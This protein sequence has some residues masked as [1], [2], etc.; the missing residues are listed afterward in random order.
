[1][2]PVKSNVSIT[3]NGQI[4]LAQ[5]DIAIIPNIAYSIPDF[6]GQ[7]ILRIFANSTQ[8]EIAC[9]SAVVTNGATFSHPAA[10]GTIL[11]IFAFVAVIA[12]FVTAIY[13]TDIPTMRTHYAHSLSVLVVFAVFQHIFFTGA[14]SMNWPSVLVAFWSNYAW[15]AGI[16]Y[17][18]S[19]QDAF[20]KLTHNNRGNTSM[21]GAAGTDTW[22]SNVGGGYDIHQIYKRA[23]AFNP[24][25]LSK[26]FEQ[27]LSKRASSGT[28]NI[29]TTKYM[30]HLVRAG[31]PLPGNYSGFPG[32]LYEEEI[33]ASNA[34]LT[35]LVWF[36]V[37]ILI[38]G[39]G[40]LFFKFAIEGLS[41]MKVIKTE[42]LNYFRAHYLGY[43]TAAVL[44]TCFIGFFAM[45][46]YTLFQF[47]YGGSAAVL[48]IAGIVFAIFFIGI[49]GVVGYA[50]YY[51]LRFD[52]WAS[53]RGRYESSTLLGFI[54]WF[55]HQQ[56]RLLDV[57]TDE[58][59][60]PAAEKKLAVDRKVTDSSENFSAV[61][62]STLHM[63]ESQKSVH[64]DEQFIK[65]FGWLASRYRK[66]K[67]WF[68][69]AWIVYEFVR[70]C[71]FAG[72]S[73]H[74]MVQVFGLLIV[75]FIAFMAI[76][77][78]RPFEG[79][80]LNLI[81]VYLLG[82]SKVAT[83]AL[84]AA[85]D[86]SFNLQR[87]T[88]TAIG[89][90]IIVIQGVVT[91]V[92]MICIV[93]SA[94]TSYFSV[95]RYREEIKPKK[96]NKH[97]EKYFK[98]LNQAVRDRPV[99]PPLV[100]PTPP[101]EE[102]K[103]PY[104]SV[105]SVRRAPKIEDEDPEFLADIAMDPRTSMDPEM[106]RTS[107]NNIDNIYDNREA[108]GTGVSRPLSTSSRRPVTHLPYAARVHRGS[109]S[110]RDFSEFN[111]GLGAAA[112]TATPLSDNEGMRPASRQY[113]TLKSYNSRD[114]IQRSATT[115]RSRSA[116]AIVAEEIGI[117]DT[118]S[119]VYHNSATSTP[120]ISRSASLRDAITA[121]AAVEASSPNGEKEKPLSPINTA[122]VR[123]VDNSNISPPPSPRDPSH[124]RSR[125]QKHK[126]EKSIAEG[127]EEWP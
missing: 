30:G 86:I 32:T 20:D 1:M 123:G 112:V 14:L 7:A 61:A 110:T 35:A 22:A 56:P 75:E 69:A 66:S 116:S 41:K 58:N 100:E 39:S 118:V 13:G 121:A 3:A 88:T 44:R 65:R 4:P 114:S 5:S 89:I 54:P 29:T 37:L 25:T 79:Q 124:T 93:L 80:R 71:F 97:Q 2:C 42:R 36:L 76:I 107:F 59:S 127:H 70:A 119:P 85:F 78:I 60:T 46:F 122:I 103:G 62:P 18:Q 19:M 115:G 48:A 108:P 15:S 6:E 24:P 67:W 16:I 92:L 45:M 74:A 8:S 126:A 82:F 94:I 120:A 72:A 98:H 83:V 33:P 117:S 49:F 43:L 109:W 17:T 51:K 101:P 27:I 104:F 28:D 26:R 34:F 99:T 52:T 23:L 113:P 111:D 9:Y 11:G 106:S 87:I 64:D 81:I 77:Q 105:N 47:S 68:F 73:G 38:V 96:W 95:M 55:C 40:V 91:I 10:A 57:P 12:S 50:C 53:I 84:S 63:A 125:L 31:L 21:L 90:V 102:P